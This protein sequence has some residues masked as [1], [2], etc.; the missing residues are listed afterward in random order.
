MEEGEICESQT[1]S[2]ETRCYSMPI[3]KAMLQLSTTSDRTS[4]FLTS[5]GS[6]NKTKLLKR[7]MLVNLAYKSSSGNSSKKRQSG[8][9][10]KLPMKSRHKGDKR[11]A[12]HCDR[13]SSR[14]RKRN[15]DNDDLREESDIKGK[16]KMAVNETS[17]HTS[18]VKQEPLEE[19]EIKE[20]SQEL[21]EEK[22]H[23]KRS[24]YEPREEAVVLRKEPRKISSGYSTKNIIRSQTRSNYI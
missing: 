11:P 20:T 21:Y 17:S 3:S 22:H 8:A 24:K 1:K 5:H 12:D 2:F 14:L 9:F 16:P 23:R 13:Q 4:S 10:L 6:C 19:G 15:L 18:V 7:S